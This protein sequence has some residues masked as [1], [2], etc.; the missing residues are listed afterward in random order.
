MKKE[1]SF[2]PF[3]AVSREH[4]QLR[5]YLHSTTTHKQVEAVLVYKLRRGLYL[6]KN[7]TNILFA[8]QDLLYHLLETWIK[9]G[10]TSSRFVPSSIQRVLYVEK[11][12]ST[13]ATKQT[14]SNTTNG[15]S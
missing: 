5:V 1:R 15:H 8:T 13:E 7:W 12:L 6:T 4:F 14:T 11:E 10:Y 2:F 9:Q 3:L